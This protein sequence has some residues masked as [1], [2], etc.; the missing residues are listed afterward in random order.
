MWFKDLHADLA[1]D[2]RRY[3][4]A[5][6]CLRNSFNQK[7]RATCVKAGTMDGAVPE[8]PREGCQKDAATGRAGHETGT[9]PQ[10]TMLGRRVILIVDI[11]TL[12]PDGQRLD[13]ELEFRRQQKGLR[14][15][16]CPH[17]ASY[18]G[19]RHGFRAIRREQFWW[20]FFG[21]L[22]TFVSSSLD[23][24]SSVDPG[25]NEA[26]RAR[27]I[28]KFTKAGT[29]DDERRVINMASHD[30]AIRFPD[31]ETVQSYVAKIIRR[32]GY[33]RAVLVQSRG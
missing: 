32:E 26:E 27:A 12:A 29:D 7:Q 1:R 20:S 15:I 14:M 31:N 4:D 22:R 17:L 23:T 10:M 28:D 3:G 5:L 11:S 8:H 25:D 19:I 33:F 24:M 18:T 21:F 2:Y 13:A 16:L 30:I 9:T 6:G